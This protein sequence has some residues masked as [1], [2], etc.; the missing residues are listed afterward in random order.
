MKKLIL[1]SFILFLVSGF[2][3]SADEF[4]D[5]VN[6]GIVYMK[7]GKY[8]KALEIFNEA[9]NMSPD[10][11][12]IYY[13]LGEVYFRQGKTTDALTNYRKAIEMEPKNPD[14]HYAIA[15][16]YLAQ[17]NEKEALKELDKTIKLSPQSIFAKQAE[18]LK[19]KI[20]TSAREKEIVKR[21]VKLEEEERRK[22]EEEEKKKEEGMPGEQPPGMGPE[23]PGMPGG[24]EMETLKKEKIPV[25]KLIKRI[26]YGTKS[27]REKSSL[28]LLSYSPTELTKVAKEII[29]LTKKEKSDEIRKNLI[30]VVGK[31]KTPEAANLLLSII[32]NKDEKFQIRLV[33]LESIKELREKRVILTLRNTLKSM[34]ERRE[35]EREEARKNI[36]S[37]T[38]EIENLQVQKIA[39][40]SEIQKL[41]QEKNSI[42]MKLQGSAF[43]PEMVPPEA[44]GMGVPPEFQVLKPEEVKKYRSR[45]KKIE[46]DISQKRE[47]LN[48]IEKKIEELE[49]KRRKYQILLARKEGREIKISFGT[50]Q[51]G[52]SPFPPEMGMP[53]GEFMPGYTPEVQETDEEK[54]EI[55]FALTLMRVLGDLKDKEALPIIKKAWKEYGVSNQRIYYILTLAKLG[56]YRK[57]K[58]LI[59][60]LK[61]DYPA[62]S[63]EEE[64]KLRSEILGV[65][66]EYLKTHPDKELTGLVEFLS[67]EGQYPEIK[68]AA[69]KVLSSLGKTVKK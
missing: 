9:R 53:P 32:E 3:Y 39:L 62:G 58:L 42:E 64:I 17:N 66:G 33:A 18:R 26:R 13:Y 41:E 35:K 47:K 45:L 50:P 22:K 37:L 28:L 40:N 4:I 43:A 59:N 34:I 63:K 6:K 25:K 30:R 38:E 20:E 52:P 65:I 54:N 51:A 69:S 12:L 60:R 29:E 67:E 44:A 57:I 21:W 7:I 14:Y 27:V 8:G 48:E 15:L 2:I 1:I 68:N 49:K 10:N 11:P 55:I 61:Q 56:D 24:V 16:V 23:I 31:L 5:K 46:K 19:K 36:K